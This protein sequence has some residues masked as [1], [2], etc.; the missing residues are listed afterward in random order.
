MHFQDRIITTLQQV[1]VGIELEIHTI[2]YFCPFKDKDIQI[3]VLG[4]RVAW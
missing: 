1:V 4:G 2:K 3:Q